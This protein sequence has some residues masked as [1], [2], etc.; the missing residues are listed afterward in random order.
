MILVIDDFMT[1]LSRRHRKGTNMSE[2]KTPAGWYADP[3]G[4]ASKQRYWNGEAWTDSIQDVSPGVAQSANQPVVSNPSITSEENADD[5]KR[6]KILLIVTITVSLLISILATASSAS[7]YF[8][9]GETRMATSGLAQGMIRFALE[10]ALFVCVYQGFNWARIV[11]IGLYGIGLAVGMM[12][13]VAVS[14]VPSAMAMMM[15]LD[16]V[17]IF[18]FIS[19]L[20]KPVKAYQRDKRAQKP[21]A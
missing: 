5:V 19:L 9:L 7:T 4:D 10:C 17:Y 8:S 16:A 3:S 13:L 21:Q 2:G 6:G 11:A 14:S 20:S 18:I 1:A 12:S 15:V